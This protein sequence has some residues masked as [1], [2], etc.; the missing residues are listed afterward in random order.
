MV[1]CDPDGLR[2]LADVVDGFRRSLDVA[3]DD[4]DRSINALD[5][6]GSDADR[7]RSDWQRIN[8][9]AA[10]HTD[11][12]LQRV[13]T[14]LRR[15]ADAQTKVSAAGGQSD[16]GGTNNQPT[17]KNDADSTDKDDLPEDLR[18]FLE[19]LGLT[20][21]DLDR[22]AE[23]IG[24]SSTLQG[25]LELLADLGDN[26]ALT[27]MLSTLG[28][29]LDVVDVVVDF[30]QDFGEHSELS[31]DERIVHA[32]ASAAMAFGMTQGI[33]VACTALG[34]AIGSALFP[35]LGT[36]ALGAVGKAIG[37]GASELTEFVLDKTGTEEAIT[38]G[39]ADAYTKLYTTV[40][41]NVPA[42]VENIEKG[43]ETIIDFGS[44]V[45]TMAI[46]GAGKLIDGTKDVI[47]GIANTAGGVI[48]KLNP[49]G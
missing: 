31:I 28:K 38:E 46:D 33:D 23:I 40:R 42:I 49:F 16:G 41:D 14:A 47:E 8:R 29:A 35:G 39:Y 43:V 44:D 13:G 34:A 4:I 6:I 24:A 27:G 37:W 22:I 48:S 32:G 25:A 9:S 12:L 15:N 20:G 26:K 19:K 18:E 45:G 11:D 3:V 21:D 2:T 17:S 36:V 1:G 10:G 30:A 5:W 7:L